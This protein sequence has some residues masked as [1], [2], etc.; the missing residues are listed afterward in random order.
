MKKLLLS[1]TALLMTVPYF[2][3]TSYAEDVNVDNLE[4]D[5]EWWTS[6]PGRI[7]PNDSNLDLDSLPP[8]SAE[9]VLVEDKLTRDKQTIA[10][11]SGQ[12]YLNRDGLYWD[13]TS[14]TSVDDV[15]ASFSVVGTLYKKV[16]ST[17][18]LD[19]LDQDNDTQWFGKGLVIAQTEGKTGV[20]GDVMIAEG[21]HSVN[22]G[23]VTD[24]VVT[25]EKYELK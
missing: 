22:L 20:V 7:D 10:S 25:T 12:T 8:S 21:I 16:K 3:T 11:G 15:V 1:C 5:T 19:Q 9:I 6:V 17:G 23:M 2:T 14:A 4:N 24:T 18:K 13:G